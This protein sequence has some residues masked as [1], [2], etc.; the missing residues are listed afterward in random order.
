MYDQIA[1]L[2]HLVYSDW[3]AA[4]AL[5]ATALDAIIRTHVGSSPRSIL[6]VS[7]G[8]GT[9]A[10]GLAALGHAVTASDLSSAAVERARREAARR[11]L[12]IHFMVADMRR[13]AE[14][15][16]SGFDVLLSADNSIPHLLS[17]DAIREALGSFH[18]CIRPGGIAIL[19]VRD[20]LRVGRSSPQLV[21][22]GFRSDG[23][24]R[25]FVVQTRDWDGDFYDVAMYFI[26][27]GRGSKPATVIS[28]SSRYYAVPMDRLVSLLEESAFSEIQRLDGGLNQ[29]VLVAR[30]T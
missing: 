5:Q 22:Y 4:I 26:R 30:R 1:A 13:C 12:A 19:G 23:D 3:N 18:Q 9:Q 14:L 10:L 27:E 28:G 20:Y 15:H 8:I 11:N 24:D 6:D 17:D 7:C 29:P 2:Y 16:G 25:Y 21:P